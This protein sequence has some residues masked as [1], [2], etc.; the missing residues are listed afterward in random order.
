M[1]C[2]VNNAS[3]S[4]HSHTSLYRVWD[5]RGR[6]LYVGITG[7]GMSRLFEHAAGKTWWVD[8]SKVTV[9]HFA[10]RVAA[11]EAELQAIRIERPRHNRRDTFHWTWQGLLRML[12]WAAPTLV[13]GYALALT[14]AAT[15]V[16]A[17]WHNAVSGHSTESVLGHAFAISCFSVSFHRLATQPLGRSTP[18]S[19]WALLLG[20]DAVQALLQV[21]PR[22]AL[23]HPTEST[24]PWTLVVL[25]L[26]ITSITPILC[27]LVWRSRGDMYRDAGWLVPGDSRTAPETA[28]ALIH[29]R[30]S[31]LRR[32]HGLSAGAA[33]S[34]VGMS[35]PKQR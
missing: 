26:T 6:L 3:E 9:V 22:L 17:M 27:L 12:S 10:S 8:V 5:S 11:E 19:W 21:R 4:P 35:A 2:V 1:S 32:R 31:D 33:E 24:P 29:R 34:S 15:A 23:T 7:R 20:S 28:T 18:I 13:A 14:T 25:L 30:L 16:Q